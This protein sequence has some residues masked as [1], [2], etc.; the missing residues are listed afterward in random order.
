VDRFSPVGAIVGVDFAGT[1]AEL[2]PGVDG[3]KLK[4]G[5]R[6]ASFIRG[7]IHSSTLLLDSACTQ[8]IAISFQVLAITDPLPNTS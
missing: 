2:G 7:G 8:A 4:I 3:E 1:I 5:D 6:V